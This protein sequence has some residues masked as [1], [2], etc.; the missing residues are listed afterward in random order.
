MKIIRHSLS[1]RSV[2][3]AHPSRQTT[4]RMDQI[5]T[6]QR[7][8]IWRFVGAALVPFIV[9]SVY[10]IFS[11]WPSYRFTAFSDGAGIFGPILI[12]AMFI[13]TLPIRPR[14][15]VFSLLIY[16]PAFAVL[17]FFYTLLFIALVFHEGL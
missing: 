11:R 5:E 15:R 10:L 6:T 2:A 12:G 17:L 3:V 4:K 8:C 7:G 13:A 1:A 16:V 14:L 9:T